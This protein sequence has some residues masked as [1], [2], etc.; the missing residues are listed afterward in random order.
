MKV[1]AS[2]TQTAATYYT[3][4]NDHLGT[5]MKLLNQSG[6]TVWSATYDAFGRATVDAASTVTNNLRYPGQYYDAETGLHYNWMRYYDP[7]AGRYV[8]GDPISLYGGIN[9]YAYVG[10]SPMKYIDPYGL[11]IALTNNQIELIGGVVGG[12]AAGFTTSGFAGAIAGGVIGGMS[13]YTIQQY[14]KNNVGGQMAVG[15]LAGAGSGGG[16]KIAGALVGAAT[17]G[18]MGSGNQDGD[19]GNTTSGLAGGA[20]GGAVS[21]FVTKGPRYRVITYAGS[22][23]WAGLV[24]GFFQDFTLALLKANQCKGGDYCGQ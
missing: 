1:P 13:T 14:Y 18:I 23:G 17:S 16:N 21:G 3:Y 2:G 24:G 8:T 22:A 4:Q 10:A 11:C 12:A 7:N 15:A 6:V 9:L 5:P 20:L 19:W